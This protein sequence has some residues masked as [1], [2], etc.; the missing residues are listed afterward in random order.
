MEV[1]LLV[2]HVVVAITVVVLVLIQHGKG[3]DAGAAFG[4][5]SS[6]SASVFGSRGSANFMSRVTAV[7]A[8]TFFVTSMS[9]TYLAIKKPSAGQGVMTTQPVTGEK[10][11][12][13]GQIPPTA[14]PAAQSD[15]PTVPK[16]D[17]PTAPKS[18]VPADASSKKDVSK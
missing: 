3:A 10:S 13:P 5:G 4:G 2:V 18:D 15:V 1:F 6:G 12:L 16:S 8:A 11:S 14:A 17:V 9:L 7:L